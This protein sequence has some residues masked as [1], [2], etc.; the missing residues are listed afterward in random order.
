M[1]GVSRRDFV[2]LGAAGAVGVPL[3]LDPTRAHA[4]ATT[5]QDIVDRIRK[6]VGV[7][8]RPDTAD[9]FKAG[10]P[11]TV[12]TGIATTS[13]ATIDVMRRAVQAGANMI[14]TSGPT[15]YSRADLP[16]PPAGRGRAAAPPSPDPV[17]VAKNE[18]IKTNK[19]VVW[20]F[21]DHWRLRTPNPFTTGLMDALEWTK[22]RAT[23]DPLTVTVP[24]ITLDRLVED[25]N[26][27]LKAR[28]GMRVVGQGRM[29]VRTIGFLPGS[30]PIQMTLNLL[31]QV[32]ALIA[33]EIREWESSE[34]ARDTVSEGLPRA[35]ILLGR[36]LSEDPGMRACAQWL[37]TIVP[38]VRCR[39]MPVGDPYWRPA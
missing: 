34:Y 37:E 8:W 16:T 31:P 3:V 28:G 35:L 14:I 32:D 39:W 30:A 25:V 27:K 6:S 5:A 13:L 22:Y 20:R 1:T 33:G 11:A 17:F 15:F 29:R 24:S 26:R 36:T 10:D 9:T 7:E 18:F 19:L 4:A 12:V 2:R 21:S 38:D 23:G